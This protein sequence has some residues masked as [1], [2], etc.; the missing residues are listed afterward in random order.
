M[1]G[2]L[3]CIIFIIGC[4]SSPEDG[5]SPKKSEPCVE[6]AW[7]ADRDGDGYGNNQ[8][9][10]EA[11]EAPEGFLPG[12]GDCDDTDPTLN[13]KASERCDGLDN[14]CN[15]ERDDNATD[16]P[17]WF[18]DGDGDGFGDDSTTD[19]GCEAPTGHVAQPGDC[20]DIDPLTFPGAD[21]LCDALDNDCDGNLPIEEIDVDGDG[22]LACLDDCDDGDPNSYPYNTELCDGNDNDCDGQIDNDPA[23]GD[24]WFDD[25]DTDGYGSFITG[26]Q[27]CSP[28]VGQVDDGT[29]CDDSDGTV[30]PGAL[31]TVADLSDQNC[32]GLELCFEDLDGDG[33]GTANTVLTALITCSGPGAALTPDDCD[34][35]DSHVFPGNIETPYDG[36]DN[37]CDPLSPDDDLDGDGFLDADDCDDTNAM[38]IPDPGGELFEEIALQAGISQLQW[39]VNVNPFEC[40][41]FINIA[42]GAA[43]ADF[44]EDGRLDIFVTRLQLPDLLYL[45]QPNGTYVDVAAARGIDHTGTSAAAKWIDVDGDGDLDLYVASAGMEDNRLYINDGGGFFTEEAVLRGADAARTGP[46]VCNQTY[47]L[48]AG[49]YDGDGDL[50]IHTDAWYM[51]YLPATERNILLDNDGTGYFTDATAAAGL[52]MVG[53]AGFA[54]SWVD[55]D[56]DGDQDFS[57]AADW[58]SSGLWVKDGGVFTSVTVAAQIDIANG[59][60]STW[61][62][63]DRDGDLDWFT[64]A[65]FFPGGLVCAGDCNGNRLYANDG[66]GNFTDVTDAAGVRDGGWGWGA[67]FFDFDNDGDLDLGQAEGPI[68]PTFVSS[69]TRIWQNDGGGVYAEKGCELGLTDI[70][71]ERAFIP[72]DMDGDGDLDLL[73]TESENPPRLY[74][75][76]SDGTNS[77]LTIELRDPTTPGNQRAIGAV[78]KI[79]PLIGNGIQLANIHANDTFGAQLP[80]EAHFGLGLHPGTV[81]KLTIVWPDGDMDV[82]TNLPPR[83]HMVIDRS[84]L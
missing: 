5:N 66:V 54:S 78:L 53:V 15:G 32:D 29:D 26:A 8:D 19:V 25:D 73:I 64:S 12:P 82:L 24:W 39:D 56:N 83:S 57:I 75:N 70:G 71:N 1:R 43:V 47:G 42:A 27:W 62:D 34:D 10:V 49:D 59:M 65:I 20:D 18:F 84:T 46:N 45:S 22:H 2:V 68:D 11:C 60:G 9:T 76:L 41:P 58:A 7:Y 81:D 72:F 63:Y 21:E 77:W 37:D 67:A 55:I 30:H 74:R 6:K 3:W 69:A 79:E 51:E 4:G 61:A 16:A 50:D 28:P 35:A 36:L 48:S 33:T 40:F 13:P 31:E 80:T 23:D 17:T 52:E 38:V 44:D 14:D